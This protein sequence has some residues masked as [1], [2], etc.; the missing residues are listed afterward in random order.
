[1]L[2]GIELGSSKVGPALPLAVRS[3]A[4]NDRFSYGRP[5][6]SESIFASNSPSLVSSSVYKPLNTRGIGAGGDAGL[7]V[8]VGPGVAVD[9]PGATVGPGVAVGPGVVNV[10]RGVASGATVLVGTGVWFAENVVAGSSVGV[11]VVSS[12]LEHATAAARMI[13]RIANTACLRTRLLFHKRLL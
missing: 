10:D 4:K 6:H 5:S 7:G 1:M 2:P 11:G 9:W 12:D 8:A 13:P 3:S